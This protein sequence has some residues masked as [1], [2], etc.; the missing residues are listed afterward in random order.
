MT[1]YN[2][3]KGSYYRDSIFFKYLGTSCLKRF[4]ESSKFFKKMERDQDAIPILTI[5][6]IVLF[7]QFAPALAQS[8]S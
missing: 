2:H 1:H 4:F 8:D 5:L 7:W 3:I 6:S